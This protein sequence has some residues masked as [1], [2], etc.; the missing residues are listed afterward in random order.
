MC[1][2]MYIIYNIYIYTYTNNLY[3]YISK[4]KPLQARCGPDGGRRYSSTLP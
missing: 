3:I 2:Y 1:I 4:V